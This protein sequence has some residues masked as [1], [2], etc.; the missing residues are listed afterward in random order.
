MPPSDWVFDFRSLSRWLKRQRKFVMARALEQARI[1]IDAG[2]YSD[3][4]L[5][6][7]EILLH[8]PLATYDELDA[9]QMLLHLEKEARDYVLG[10][11]AEWNDDSIAAYGGVG[12][13]QMELAFLEIVPVE[14]ISLDTKSS[15][16]SPPSPARSLDSSLARSTVEDH[17][18]TSPAGDRSLQ[19]K[20]SRFEET[21]ELIAGGE[22]ATVEFKETLEFV[23]RLDPN[24]PP[25]LRTKKLQEKQAERVHSVL[26]SVC[27]FLN[28]KGGTLLIGVH[29]KGDITGIEPDFTLF[30]NPKDKDK[31]GFERKLRSLLDAR[32]N[33][34]P[35]GLVH[36][37]FIPIEGKEVARI[38]VDAAR[39]PFYLDGDYF[40]RDGN[41]TITLIDDE[42][43]SYIALGRNRIGRPNNEVRMIDLDLW[44]PLAAA[45]RKEV[46][47][48]LTSYLEVS[49]V[50]SEAIAFV[51]SAIYYEV[52]FSPT[53]AR[54]LLS[55]TALLHETIEFRLLDWR[56]RFL[57]SDLPKYEIAS[58]DVLEVISPAESAEL[59]VVTFRER[60]NQVPLDAIDRQLLESLS[61]GTKLTEISKAMNTT[62]ASLKHRMARLKPILK[63]YLDLP[64]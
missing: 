29:D 12:A 50:Q 47:R 21:T 31:D 18:G 32:L 2:P 10:N 42:R 54:L 17:W 9:A 60:L 63:R 22:T 27:A 51:E 6:S 46:S 23:D 13:V 26:K 55:E 35:I 28:T 20:V 62:R 37:M 40:V 1:E 39:D 43:D 58:S 24:I 38:D 7:I 5:H 15:D 8:V 49:M 56:R 4:E 52:C 3:H 41:R 36:C 59:D 61:E 33:R 11:I 16:S 57:G 30:S 25:E 45:I 19:S 34:R 14:P 64:D 48:I 44:E 53:K